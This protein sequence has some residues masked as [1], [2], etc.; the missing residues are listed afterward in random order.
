MLRNLERFAQPI[1]MATWRLK[2][3]E[4]EF[5]L[6]FMSTRHEKSTTA[7]TTT[8]TTT[9]TNQKKTSPHLEPSFL[10]KV[11][12]PHA[13]RHVVRRRQSWRRRG[14][15]GS[16]QACGGSG[17]PRDHRCLRPRQ[18]QVSWLVLDRKKTYLVSKVVSTHPDIA[19]PRQ[20]PVRQLWKKSLFSLLVKV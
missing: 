17:R 13:T 20:S 15:S 2:K 16:R 9:T 18:R 8:T 5:C 19:H 14:G 7:T 12:D 11:T 6:S 10:T 3:I 1:R 4:V